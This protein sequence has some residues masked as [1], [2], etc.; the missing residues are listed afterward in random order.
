MISLDYLLGVN[1][2]LLNPNVL[3]V[4]QDQLVKPANQVHP[5]NLAPVVKTVNLVLPALHVP[6]K[7]QLA[8]NALLDNLV[9]PDLTDLLDLLVPMGNLV[10]LVHKL[11]LD[12]LDL[13]ALL[14]MQAPLVNLVL[15]ALLVTKV[16]MVKEA[17]GLLAPKDLLEILAQLELLVLMEIQD[18]MVNLDLQVP[19]DPLVLLVLLVAM[20]NLVNPVVQVFLVQMPPTVLAHLDQLSSSAV[21][22]KLTSFLAKKLPIVPVPLILLFSSIFNKKRICFP[23]FF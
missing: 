21:A 13:P 14:E 5:D 20:V 3:L 12:N 6:L 16:L 8:S 10:L 1:A 2:S 23:L 19:L 17:Q 7:T 11:N 22:H 9:L 4:L 18:Q 15:L